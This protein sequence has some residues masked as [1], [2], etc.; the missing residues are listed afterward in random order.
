MRLP[1]TTYS[2]ST[3]RFLLEYKIDLGIEILPMRSMQ[4]EMSSGLGY[5]E[6]ALCDLVK[7]GRSV[8]AVPL[9][10]VGIAL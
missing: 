2:S 9:I 5:Y 8:P 4:S 6:G 10:L 1:S 7:R 3:L